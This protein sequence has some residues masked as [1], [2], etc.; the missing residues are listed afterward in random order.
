MMKKSWWKIGLVA[1]GLAF[2]FAVPQIREIHYQS[3]YY[4]LMGLLAVIATI[5]IVYEEHF[6]ERFY[7]R[8]KKFREQG[9]WINFLR[10]GI[11]AMAVMTATVSAGQFFVNGVTPLEIVERLSGGL[12]PVILVLLFAS[13]LSGIVGWYQNEKRYAKICWRKKYN[14][15]DI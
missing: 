13:V 3:Y 7:R 9:F 11:S 8:W 4:A 6:E 1:M 14:N 2:L 5:E 10:R 12:M 15:Y